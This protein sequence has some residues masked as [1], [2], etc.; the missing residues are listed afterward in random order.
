MVQ[1]AGRVAVVVILEQQVL[2][3]LDKATLV[4]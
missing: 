4:V 1:L 3:H 2:P